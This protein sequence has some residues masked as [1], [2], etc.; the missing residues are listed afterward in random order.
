MGSWEK[1][2]LNIYHELNKAN[3]GKANVIN[4]AKAIPKNLEERMN[5]VKSRS[6]VKGSR[7]TGRQQR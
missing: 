6:A 4:I 1:L 7:A 2:T 5:A 3:E